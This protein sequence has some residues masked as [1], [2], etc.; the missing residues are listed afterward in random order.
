MIEIKSSNIDNKGNI[1]KIINY[2]N[3]TQS[4]IQSIYKLLK[5][6]N[7]INDK[8]ELKD[9]FQNKAYKNGKGALFYFIDNEAV[10]SICVVLESAKT[11][12]NSFI[13]DITINKEINNKYAIL[14]LLIKEGISL[15]KEHGANDIRLGISPDVIEVFKSLGFK[16]EYRALQ[17]EL[18]DTDKRCEILQLKELNYYNKEKYIK[19]YNSSFKD[20]PHGCIIC[21]EDVKEYLRKINNNNDKTHFYYIVCDNQDEIGFMEVT[22][23]DGKGMFDIGLCKKYRGMG[24]GSRLLETAISFLVELGASVNLI[25]IED[26]KVAYEMYKKRGFEE[27]FIKSYWKKLNV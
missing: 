22:I 25:V 14:E 4:Q 15:S 20:M 23:E 13:Y 8:E 21:E 18:N 6:Q 17:M 3:P 19:I 9:K 7:K 2:E 10:A 26:N 11:I 1:H 24:Y 16:D 27:S 5:N 12:G